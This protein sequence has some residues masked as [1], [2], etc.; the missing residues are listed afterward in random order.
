[1]HRCGQGHPGVGVRQVHN[2]GF[3]PLAKEATRMVGYW[4]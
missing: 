2:V 3:A 4:P 1:M